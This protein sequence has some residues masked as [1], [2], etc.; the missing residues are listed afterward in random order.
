LVVFYIGVATSVSG[1]QTQ[2]A[3]NYFF[4]QTIIFFTK[5]KFSLVNT[6][7]A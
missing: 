5:K 1:G 3:K 6:P 7:V 2:Q 4:S